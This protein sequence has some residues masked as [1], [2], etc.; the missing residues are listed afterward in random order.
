MLDKIRQNNAIGVSD[1]S[2]QILIKFHSNSPAIKLKILTVL[3][4]EFFAHQK[5]GYNNNASLKK[6]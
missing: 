4:L 2:S 3:F 5:D 1:C 6:P